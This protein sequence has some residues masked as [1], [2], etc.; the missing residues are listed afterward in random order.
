MIT[1]DG[2]KMSKSKGNVVSPGAIVARTAPT[3]RAAYI[4]FIGPPDQDAD[5][6]DEGVEGVHRFLSR[7][8]RLGADVAGRGRRRDWPRQPAEGADLVLVRKANW[9][10][11]KV[12]ADMRRALRV[13]HG[14]RRGDGADERGLAACATRPATGA[15]RFALA[16]ANS[17]LFPFAPHAAADVYDLLTGA[18][19]G[20]SRGRSPTRRSW[21]SDT[22]ELVCQVN[23]KLRDRVEAPPT[24]I[25]RR[26][27]RWRG[28]AERARA[29]RRPGG[30]EGRSSCPASS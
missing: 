29:R 8:W 21:R 3:P 23:G 25:A 28:G 30:R 6:S 22:Y 12:T 11:D 20:R 7:L 4:L 5:W 1:K 26:S 17:L 14:D 16:T 19:S 15:L 18:G 2:A 24:P 27:R 9:A 13:Q 10:I